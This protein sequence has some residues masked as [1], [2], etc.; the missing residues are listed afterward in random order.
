M[1]PCYG[2]LPLDCSCFLHSN[3]FI[4]D[5]QVPSGTFSVR[6]PIDR[7]FQYRN[8]EEF[9]Q[10]NAALV[11]SLQALT[12]GNECVDVLLNEIRAE[13]LR[14]ERMDEDDLRRKAA[15]DDIL[16]SSDE[17]QERVEA[18]LP[19]DAQSDAFHPQFCEIVASA[20]RDGMDKNSLLNLHSNIIKK[21]GHD[22]Y[23]F[24]VF[25]THYV[26]R[27]LEAFKSFN[28]LC[29]D[30]KGRPN[31][32]N[33]QGVL[34]HEAGLT[35]AF[36]N[37]CLQSWISPLAALLLPQYGGG[38]LDNHRC[39]TV[40]YEVGQ[41][42]G[43]SRH[44][45]NCEVTLNI[46]LGGSFTHGGELVFFPDSYGGVHQDIVHCGNNNPGYAV[47]HPGQT[48]HKATPITNGDRTNLIFWC[49]STTQRKI[50]GCPMCG[51]TENLKEPPPATLEQPTTCMVF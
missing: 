1:P 17:W 27:L 42:E 37:V 45:D 16:R 33:K 40:Q 9:L 10:E 35:S 49:R 19:L 24:P 43:L 12:D 44:F 2:Q 25:T 38:T 8:K 26:Q 28:I 5:I 41:D 23:T 22:I 46:A 48:Q 34:L 31:S 39:F 21:L 20:R 6:V 32:M 51:S 29:N 11:S 50:D 3:I 4:K 15:C 47:L 13:V 36:T 7:H 30:T 14:R 18:I